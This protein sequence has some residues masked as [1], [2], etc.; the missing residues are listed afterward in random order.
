MFYEPYFMIFLM[1]L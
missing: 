1:V